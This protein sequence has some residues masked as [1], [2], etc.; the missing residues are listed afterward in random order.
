MPALAGC[1]AA[2]SPA[3]VVGYQPEYLA[4][5]ANGGSVHEL[6]LLPTFCLWF[7]GPSRRMP[8]A[9]PGLRVGSTILV[10][11]ETVG[12]DAHDIWAAVSI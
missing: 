9:G 3:E 6:P 11:L 1:M 8:A 10:P 5:R 12:I 7:M 4:G 2:G